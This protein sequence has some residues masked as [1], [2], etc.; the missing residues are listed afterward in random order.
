MFIGFTFSGKCPSCFIVKLNIHLVAF[1][2]PR[3]Q[4]WH[5][6]ESPRPHAAAALTY[7]GHTNMLLLQLS[8]MSFLSLL[9]LLPHALASLFSLCLSL[10]LPLL[11]ALRHSHVSTVTATSSGDSSH[12]HVDQ[13]ATF[14]LNDLDNR[15]SWGPTFP[16]SN[17]SLASAPAAFCIDLS[18]CSPT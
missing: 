17:P 7:C 2:V 4:T 15:R 9:H 16:R 5:V 13:A 18:V 12:E 8:T 3:L 10:S 1:L 14:R 6:L 11:P